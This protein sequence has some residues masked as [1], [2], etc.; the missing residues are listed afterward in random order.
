[1]SSRL[2][3]REKIFRCIRRTNVYN[4]ERFIEL[5]AW[6]AWPGGAEMRRADQDE[7]PLARADE[8]VGGTKPLAKL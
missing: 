7:R 3:W 2:Q 5:V 1:M 6:P 8:K 4:G